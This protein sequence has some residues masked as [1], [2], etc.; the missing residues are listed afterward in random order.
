MLRGVLCA[1]HVAHAEPHTHALQ[2]GSR[3]REAGSWK[4]T[5]MKGE[6]ETNT[7]FEPVATTRAVKL[8]S[9]VS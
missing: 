2:H 7:T 1:P 9:A 5:H 8:V 6:V 3:Q 4:A